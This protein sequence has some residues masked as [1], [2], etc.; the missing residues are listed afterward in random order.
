MHSIRARVEEAMAATPRAGFLRPGDVARAGDDAPVGIGAGQT[1]SQPRTV[2]D[3]LELLDVQDGD[4]VLDVGSG[5]AW[6]TA[7]LARLVGPTGTV[8]G[9]ERI[10]EVLDLGRRNLAL[11]GLTTAT[12]RLA[13]P[14]HLGS[15]A[16]SPFDRVLV[17]AMAGELPTELVD[18]LRVGGVMVVPVVGRMLRVV[19][20]KGEPRVTEHG[21]YRFVPLI[22]GE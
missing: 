3:M 17:S 11:T 15:P 10:P 13:E 19:R 20:T 8:L 4:R 21:R 22:S 7:I 2:A 6:T 18:Q 12:V 9:L 16:D 14:G 5:S 1:N